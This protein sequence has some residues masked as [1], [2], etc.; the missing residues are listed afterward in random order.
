MP[1]IVMEKMNDGDLKAQPIFAQ[2]ERCQEDVRRRAFELFEL[3]GCEPG[4][5]VEDWL[6]AEREV[7]GQL[8]LE[9]KEDDREFEFQVPLDDFDVSQVTVIVTPSEIIV[10]AK[11]EAERQAEETEALAAQFAAN[12]F[13][14]REVYRRIEL[15][16]PIEI[17]RTGAVIDSGTLRIKAAKA[18]ARMDETA[19]VAA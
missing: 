8:P 3:R 5:D 11:T 19:T 9:T 12:K 7:L 15:P 13:A 4:Q 2:I 16:Q 1:H 14:G 17:E 10:H 18:K 6:Q